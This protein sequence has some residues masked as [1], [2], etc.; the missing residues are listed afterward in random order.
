MDP[1]PQPMS[2]MRAGSTGSR[3]SRRPDHAAR[4]DESRKLWSSCSSNPSASASQNSAGVTT[5]I[6]P[7][8]DGVAR[9]KHDANLLASTNQCDRSPPRARRL[10]LRQ[11]LSG[12]SVW[13]PVEGYTSAVSGL[14]HPSA[15]G[16]NQLVPRHGPVVAQCP[17]VCVPARTSST[18]RLTVVQLRSQSV[19]EP[20]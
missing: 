19:Q 10:F 2:A 9:M 20:I 17:E 13:S 3:G 12:P 7:G 18:D 5:L 14:Q 6:V 16:V 11:R 1:V 4:T 15:K 8:S